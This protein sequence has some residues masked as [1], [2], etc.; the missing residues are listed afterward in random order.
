LATSP[1]IDYNNIFYMT[2]INKAE[3]IKDKEYLL[4]HDLRDI[5]GLSEYQA[6]INEDYNKKEKNTIQI[7]NNNISKDNQKHNSIKRINN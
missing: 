4:T 2:E 1:K 3:F 7:S 6:S 5:P